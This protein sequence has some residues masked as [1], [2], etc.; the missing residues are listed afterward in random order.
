MV[1]VK[2]CGITNLQDAKNALSAGCDALGFV[3][4]K[5]S[6]RYISPQ[7]AKDIIKGLAKDITKIGV[8]VDAGEW[9]IKEIAKSCGLNVLQFHGHESP[10]FC[11][12]FKNYKIIKAFRIKDKIDLNQILQYQTFAYLFDAFV[13]SRPGGTGKS[14]NWGLFEDLEKI[15]RPIFLS[16]GLNAR[17]VKKAVAAVRPA[18]VDASSSLEVR[19]G[20]KDPRKVKEFIR[21]A[22]H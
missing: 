9:E 2:I 5:K 14:F 3:F 22:K 4:Y 8:F 12:K 15:K 20:K 6:P 19:P 17:N 13:K 7:K 11:K 18:W 16:G 1:K 21:A 10:Q